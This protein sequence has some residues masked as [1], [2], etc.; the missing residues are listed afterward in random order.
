MAETETS[1]PDAGADD[2]VGPLEEIVDYAIAHSEDG[3]VSLK[4]LLKAWDDRSYGPLFIMLGFV[5]GTPLAVVPGAAAVVGVVIALLGLQMTLGL[6]HPWLPEAAL[7]QSVSEE[8]LREIREKMDKPLRFIDHLITE[9]WTWMAGE[10]MR[11]AAAIFVT[12]LGVL[13]IPF[14]AVPFAVAAPAWSVVLFGVAIIA[15]DGLV[16]TL[17]LAAC[18][19]VGY[20]AIGAL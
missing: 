15:R 14:D 19:G 6:N 18:L 11:R 7:K 5:G 3:R 20:L 16:M 17:A 9:R 10:A 12:I 1:K 8:K 2:D 4:A 13:M